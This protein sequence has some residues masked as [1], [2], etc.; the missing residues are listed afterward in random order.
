MF[1]CFVSSICAAWTF[2]NKET[3]NKDMLDMV[4]PDTLNNSA[5]KHQQHAFL[6]NNTTTVDGRKPANQ[7][8]LVLYPMIYKVLYIQPVVGLGISEA[9]TVLSH[10]PQLVWDQRLPI[11]GVV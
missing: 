8:K 6:A 4:E 10:S 3:S 7:L 11:S 1:L 5:M 9:S 2:S